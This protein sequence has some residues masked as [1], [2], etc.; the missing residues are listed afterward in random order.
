M[1]AGFPPILGPAQLVAGLGPRGML[2]FARL[3]LMPARA[4]G[5]ELFTDGGARAWLYGSAMHGDVPPAG[6]GSA[7]AAAYLNLLGH[8]VGWPSPEGGAGRLADALVSYLNSLG[9][10]IQTGLVGIAAKRGRVLGVCLADGERLAGHTV[11]ATIMSGA[12]ATLAGRALPSGYLGALRRYRPGPA[13]QK[14]DWAV[15]GPIPW[16]ASEARP[17]RST[18]EARRP[19]CSRQPP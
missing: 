7:I 1:L 9:G 15:D 4:L 17:E 3:L 10:A 16:S 13:T 14:V 11:I 6:S 19:R 5:E 8:G 18:S 12:L 2:E